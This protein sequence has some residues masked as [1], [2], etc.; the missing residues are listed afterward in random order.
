MDSS[1][2]EYDHEDDEYHEDSLPD[3]V[4]GAAY[5]GRQDS[6]SSH[7]SLPGIDILDRNASTSDIPD[8]VAHE[9]QVNILR[10]LF[11]CQF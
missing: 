8:H 7:D 2:D 10:K 4:M 6:V 9:M 5:R 1:C 11:E 3:L